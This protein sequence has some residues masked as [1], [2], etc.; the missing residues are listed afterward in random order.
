MKYLCALFA[1]ILLQS[2]AQAAPLYLRGYQDEQGA[3]TVQYR[4][5]FV[6]PYF[7]LKAMLSAH[8]AGLDIR[9]PAQAWIDW[10]LP[11]QRPDGSFERYCKQ[12][13]GWFAC[14]EADAD[15]ALL[16]LWI[17]FLYEMSPASGM[18]ASW[19]ASARSARL[20]LYMLRDPASGVYRISPS[21]PIG[22][23][24]D[25]VEVYAAFRGVAHELRRMKRYAEA[26]QN[27]RQAL[28]LRL[29]MERVFRPAKSGPYAVSTQAGETQGFYPQQVAQIYPLLHRMPTGDDP[30]RAF[31]S[32]MAK[33][34]D[35]WLS[36][37][38]DDFPWGLVAL[39]AIET[40]NCDAARRWLE[41][42]SPLRH[43]M[44]W[45]VLEEACLQAVSYSLASGPC[46]TERS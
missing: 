31:L 21:Q 27:L 14:K 34:G 1:A 8:A 35:G 36:M 13:G 28:A 37:T 46:K 20:R 41:R 4:G 25:N 30:H 42:A 45:N 11:R 2:C 10:L 29:A 6:D 16:A 26:E 7:A 15:D 19:Q 18:P 44:R 12:G 9:R 5:D 22:L 17:A 43:S 32:W 23:F 39:A 33:Y 40:N 24:I 3:I 38:K